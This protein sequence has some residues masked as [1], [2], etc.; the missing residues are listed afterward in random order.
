M[1]RRRAPEQDIDEKQIDE[2]GRALLQLKNEEEAR[3]FLRD[4]LSDEELIS[5]P[6]RWAIVKELDMRETQRMIADKYKCGAYTVS[7]VNA[8]LRKGEGFK[9]VLKRL[10]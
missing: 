8:A 1:G 7:R 5:I 2:L 6:K 9:L 10:R 3:L 4:L